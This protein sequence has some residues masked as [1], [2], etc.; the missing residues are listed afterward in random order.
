MST[1]NGFH[2][3]DEAE[4]L[5]P[6]CPTNNNGLV[7]SVVATVVVVAAAGGGGSG[8]GG[9]RFLGTFCARCAQTGTFCAPKPVSSDG[10]NVPKNWSPPRLFLWLR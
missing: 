5:L 8:D 4:L 10:Y 7:S 1:R 3:D 9:D 2:D 6:C